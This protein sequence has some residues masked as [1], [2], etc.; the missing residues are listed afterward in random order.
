MSNCRFYRDLGWR[1]G[2]QI[3][4]VDCD[5]SNNFKITK[6]ALEAAY[7]KAQNNNI[8]VKGLIITNPSNPLGTTLDKDTLESLV[9]FINQKNIHL[10]CDEIYAATVFSSP[11][12]ICITEDIQ[13][14]NR[15]PN[16]I[17]IVYSLSKDMKFWAGLI[18]NSAHA[19]GRRF[20]R[21]V[22]HHKRKKA[23]KEARGRPNRA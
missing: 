3:V 20:C 2:V 8:N 23:R 6:E 19:F 12:F 1:T 16:L 10:V 13:N 9:T 5:S 18:P 4:Q 7:E 22:P 21:E 17:H 15:N 11:K 14:M